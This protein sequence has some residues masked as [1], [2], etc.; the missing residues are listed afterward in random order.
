MTWQRPAHAGFFIFRRPL[1]TLKDLTDLS[2]ANRPI[3]DSDAVGL[4]EAWSRLLD[5]PDFRD[6]V[7]LQSPSLRAAIDQVRAAGKDVSSSAISMA[8]YR[9]ASRSAW[10][11]TPRGLFAGVGVGKVSD[12][13]GLG[14]VDAPDARVC[15]D[16]SLDYLGALVDQFVRHESLCRGVPLVRNPTLVRFGDSIHLRSCRFGPDRA[17]TE[18]VQLESSALLQKMVNSLGAAP[19]TPADVRRWMVACGVSAADFN[20]RLLELIE[21]EILVPALAV[22]PVSTDPVDDALCALPDAPPLLTIKNTLRTVRMAVQQ[23][24]GDPGDLRLPQLERH[25]RSLP[26]VPGF[27]AANR[28]FNVETLWTGCDV[29]L[30]GQHIKAVAKAIHCLHVLFGDLGMGRLDGVRQAFADRFGETTVPLQRLLDVTHGV[31]EVLARAAPPDRWALRGRR[32]ALLRCLCDS[33][34]DGRKAIELD[35]RFV[36]SFERTDLPPMPPACA[37]LLRCVEPSTSDGS[38]EP[39]DITLLSV[40]GCVGSE[41]WA[42]HARNDPAITEAA[43]CLRALLP[44]DEA[45]VVRADV[46]LAPPSGADLASRPGGQR[47]RILCS[48]VPPEPDTIDLTLDD[49]H[50]QIVNER[51]CLVSRRLGCEVQPVIG[52]SIDPSQVGSPAYRFLCLLAYQDW[53]TPLKWDW[54]ELNESPFLPCVRMGNVVLSP[55]RWRID[56]ADLAAVESMEAEEPSARARWRGWCERHGLPR[57]AAVRDADDALPCDLWQPWGETMIRQAVRQHGCAFIEALPSTPRSPRG[58]APNVVDQVSELIVPI[59]YSQPSGLTG[60]VSSQRVRSEDWMGKFGEGVRLPGSDWLYAKLY[61]SPFQIERL[62]RDELPA[63]LQRLRDEC[64]VRNWFFFRYRDTAW[65]LRLRLHVPQASSR[66]RA[67]EILEM[68]A[69]DLLSREAVWRL[70]FDTYFREIERFGGARGCELVEQF[71]AVESELVLRALCK[72]RDDSMCVDTALQLAASWVSWTWEQLG[73]PPAERL[74]LCR[75]LAREHQRLFHS[76]DASSEERSALAE[77]ARTSLRTRARALRRL[78]FEDVNAASSPWRGHCRRASRSLT[79]LRQLAAAGELTGGTRLLAGN[80]SHLLIARLFAKDHD[81]HE[82]NLYVQ[83][84]RLLRSLHG[85]W[86]SQNQGTVGARPDG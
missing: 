4:E 81:A 59:T 47:I 72:W 32:A 27:E 7:G 49:L 65:H 20:G 70:Q 54:G 6:A 67:R 8:V 21:T 16:L 28:A 68:A 36:A 74:T 75:A 60:Y 45:G 61:A 77:S 44:E 52:S 14:P 2:G 3:E 30:T 10:R 26:P 24:R 73:L 80:L 17:S 40:V 13:A 12:T 62:L 41:L 37:A 82:R 11:A 64:G 66:P 33:L 69:T 83:L 86:A 48:A 85:P 34:A 22:C 50:V 1:L 55:P 53:A 57:W 76:K 18:T 39:R 9:Y 31:G 63:M 79:A 58:A 56:R 29:R 43:R 35:A 15:V 46:I 42:R 25:C 38:I 84:S 5:R 51:L 23:H 71:F 19:M 78:P